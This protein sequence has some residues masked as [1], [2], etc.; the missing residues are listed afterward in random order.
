MQCL[1]L[2]RHEQGLET[3]AMAREANLVGVSLFLRLFRALATLYQQDEQPGV[4][5]KLVSSAVQRCAMFAS[6]RCAEC[7]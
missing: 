1:A 6:V 2:E 4:R 3:R 7:V 5:I